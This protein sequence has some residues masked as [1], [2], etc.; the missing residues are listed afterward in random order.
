[1]CDAGLEI[2]L[3]EAMKIVKQGRSCVR[4]NSGFVEQ[5]KTR[6]SHDYD[7][8]IRDESGMAINLEELHRK[9]RCKWEVVTKQKKPSA[10]RRT[11]RSRA[12]CW[13]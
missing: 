6:A 5:L 13:C 3:H 12:A 2:A 11:T 10:E 4:P 8:H 1:M 7:V 9:A